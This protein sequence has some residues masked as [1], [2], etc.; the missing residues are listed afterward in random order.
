MKK[1]DNLAQLYAIALDN[2]YF[3][4]DA[5]NTRTKEELERKLLEAAQK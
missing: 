1:I 4:P 3:N 2:W 5:K